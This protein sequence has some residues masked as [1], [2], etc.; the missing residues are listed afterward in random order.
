MTCL[1]K[2][3]RGHIAEEQLLIM[4][5][6]ARGFTEALGCRLP[7]LVVETEA[8]APWSQPALAR[9]GPLPSLQMGDEHSA[10]QKFAGRVVG[11]NHAKHRSACPNCRSGHIRQLFREEGNTE[12]CRSR[13]DARYLCSTCQEV[14]SGEPVRALV[15]CQA[16][17]E[18]GL[19]R[20]EVW[21]GEYI[22]EHLGLQKLKRS[23]DLSKQLCGRALK[24]VA[25]RCRGA[26]AYAGDGSFSLWA[27]EACFTGE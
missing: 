26:C 21:L 6:R 25:L 5:Q 10:W 12:S 14:F 27:M 20:C 2:Q 18:S 13:D 11:I 16:V 15:P 24:G 22:M 8:M 19:I 17:I 7:C 4:Q 9:S 23:G 1:Y 3:E